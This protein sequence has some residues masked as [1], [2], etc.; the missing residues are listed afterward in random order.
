M[1]HGNSGQRLP[2]EGGIKGRKKS[3]GISKPFIKKKMEM[4][5]TWQNVEELK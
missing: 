3:G 5:Q 4:K 2:L 1:M